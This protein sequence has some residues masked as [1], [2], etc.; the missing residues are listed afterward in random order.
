MFFFMMTCIDRMRRVVG[1]CT[2]EHE[3][4]VARLPADSPVKV[5]VK[6]HDVVLSIT[7]PSVNTEV[8]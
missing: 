5:S 6:G 7:D 4:L 2:A 3:K 1:L 8:F